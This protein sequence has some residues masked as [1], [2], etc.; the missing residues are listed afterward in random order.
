MNRLKEIRE[1]AG[2]TSR[3]LSSLIEIKE[4]R[5]GHYENGRR[6]LPVS[7]AKKIG[8]VLK[9]RWWEIYE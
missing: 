1:N 7:I 9:I 8:K 4:A 5:Y 2:L 3:E 6:E